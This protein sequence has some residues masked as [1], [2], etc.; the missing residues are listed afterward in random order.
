MNEGWLHTHLVHL[1]MVE[2]L[3]LCR[4]QVL[5]G[6]RVQGTWLHASHEGGSVHLSTRA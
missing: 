5:H 2:H 6:M 4:A 3:S 1:G